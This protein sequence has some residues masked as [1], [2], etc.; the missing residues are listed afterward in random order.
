MTSWIRAL[1]LIGLISLA[2]PG[3]AHAGLEEVAS[4][5]MKLLSGKTAS[6]SD[7]KGKMVIINFW[8]TWC[9][10]CLDEIPD[11]IKFQSKYGSKGVQVIGVNF[12]E[13]ADEK[14]L[15]EFV[16]LHGINYPIVYDD[17][18]KI[19]K[20]SNALGG[21]YGL[22]VTKILDRSGKFVGSHVGGLTVEQL[23]EFVKP[24]L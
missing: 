2:W 19:E 11:L 8:A 15:K 1:V 22:P 9:P 24:M 10:P 6:L 18:D 21:A 17:N 7:Y 12:M 13:R 23:V 3:Y 5:P 14:R 20:L 4:Q 16:E